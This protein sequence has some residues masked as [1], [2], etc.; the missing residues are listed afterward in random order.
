MAPLAPVAHCTSPVGRGLSLEP[1]RR[2][3]APESARA[4]PP[5]QELSDV[6]PASRDRCP[7]GIGR[8]CRQAIRVLTLHRGTVDGALAAAASAAMASYAT[9]WRMPLGGKIRMG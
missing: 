1:R 7:L 2:A 8:P 3:A 4:R 5:V 9:N 6:L